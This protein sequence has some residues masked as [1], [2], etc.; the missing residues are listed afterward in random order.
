MSEPTALAASEL[1]RIPDASAFGSIKILAR[2]TP[3]LSR[4]KLDWTKL[5]DRCAV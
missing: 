1:S 4:S 2:R 5:N 3:V